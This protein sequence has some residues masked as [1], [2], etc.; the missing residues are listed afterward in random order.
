MNKQDNLR[1]GSLQVEIPVETFEVERTTYVAASATPTISAKII[2]NVLFGGLRYALVAP[3]PFLITP[4]ILH[5]IGAAGYG[6]WAV[7]LAINGLTSLADMGLVGTLS[8]FVAEYY[9]RQDFLALGKLLNSGLVLFLVLAGIIVT[10]LWIGAP[11]LAGHLF[12]GSPFASGHLMALFR[13]FLI[14]IAANIL[15]LLFSSVTSGLQRLDM[16]NMLGAANVAMGALFGGALLLLGWGLRGL[17]YGYVVAGIVTLTANVVVV[18][19]LLPQVKINPMRFEVA[20]ARQMF[21]FSLQL[22]VTQAAVAV[23]NQVEK[24][25]LAML[26]GVAPVGWYDIASDVSLKIRS[27]VG[28]ILIPVLPAAS[29][30]NALGDENR[31]RELYYRTHKYLA[32]FGVPAVC[33]ATVMSRRFVELWLGPGL[34]MIAIPLSI[35]LLVNFFNLATGPG[36]CI[37][38]ARAELKPGIHS[39]LL[40]IVLNVGLSLALIYKFGFAGAVLGTSISLIA[41]STYFIAVFHRR[42]RYSLARLLREG[43]L[44]TMLAS[45]FSLAALFVLR[46]PQELSWLGLVLMTIGFGLLYSVIILLTHFFDAYDWSKIEHFV[47]LAQRLRRAS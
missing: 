9:A 30:L 15:N 40:G 34:T 37:F 11:E 39:A 32:L 24:V 36:F 16:T 45:L 31:L 25:F 2:R 20:E 44:K 17:V 19:R 29:E 41:A 33:Y 46:P 21:N 47:P 3:I 14:V 6:T 27:A 5:K 42:T 7:F 13:L 4:L 28:F 18:R 35:L 1:P 8:K 12:H 43:Y 38:A 22:Y 10:V 23:H 26:V